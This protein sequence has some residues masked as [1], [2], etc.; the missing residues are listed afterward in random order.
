MMKKICRRNNEINDNNV[1]KLLPFL[2]FSICAAANG[3]E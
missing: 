2:N 3:N 1:L